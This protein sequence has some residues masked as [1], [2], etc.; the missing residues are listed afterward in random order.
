MNN[1]ASRIKEILNEAKGRFSPKLQSLK[2]LIHPNIWEANFK[3]LGNPREPGIRQRL[4]GPY[5][6]VGC[7]RLVTS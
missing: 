5:G 4:K 1:A 2:E 7:E 6:I 3:L